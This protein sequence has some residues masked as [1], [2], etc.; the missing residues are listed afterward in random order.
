MH[1]SHVRKVSDFIDG[2]CV[3]VLGLCEACVHACAC[4]LLEATCDMRYANANRAV[5]IRYGSSGS[6]KNYGNFRASASR[7]L[8]AV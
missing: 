8:R 2:F 7:D 6:S 4:V 3:I 1:V 5:A